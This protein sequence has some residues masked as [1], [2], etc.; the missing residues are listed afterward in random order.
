MLNLFQ[1]SVQTEID[2]CFMKVED[3]IRERIYLPALRNNATKEL[4]WGSTSFLF[5][6]QGSVGFRWL[7]QLDPKLQTQ[8]L[9]D[10]KVYFKLIDTGRLLIRLDAQSLP[11]AP[12][13]VLGVLYRYLRRFNPDRPWLQTALYFWAI[14]Q[15][16]QWD[17]SDKRIIRQRKYIRN[18]G[19]ENAKGLTFK[20]YQY[21][22]ENC[23][24]EDDLAREGV[25]INKE[26]KSKNPM[27][28]F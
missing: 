27:K 21:I 15:L 7:L 2:Y 23:S 8:Y 9:I 1:P 20:V 11:T 4:V 22:V 10:P 17:V 14:A 16:Q 6:D 3:M 19:E 13:E 25:T 26:K 12:G 24:S 18:L 28:L 5:K